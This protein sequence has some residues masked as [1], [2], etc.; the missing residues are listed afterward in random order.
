MAVNTRL[1][2]YA[3]RAVNST[4]KLAKQ[5]SG[6][7]ASATKTIEASFRGLA[8]ASGSLEPPITV[9]RDTYLTQGNGLV[10]TD[11]VDEWQ[12]IRVRPQDTLAAIFERLNLDQY[13]LYQ[14][15]EVD[16]AEQL[17]H[18]KPKQTLKFRIQAGELIDL[19]Y[20]AD[21]VRRF[22]AHR[23]HGK[24]NLKIAYE[25]LGLCVFA[26]SG[27]I[28]NS[29]W[30]A[31]QAADL[32]EQMVMELVK[33]FT[34][35]I[36]FA[37]DIRE[38]DSFTVI[39][40]QYRRDGVRIEDGGILAAEF[41]NQNKRY[42][43]IRFK[44]EAGREEYYTEEGKSPRKAFFRTP[45]NFT[46]ISSYFNLKR[47]HPVLNR[48]RAHR[49]IDYAAPQGTPVKATGDGKVAF[50]GANGGYGKT[51][52][53]QHGEKYSTLYAHLSRFSRGIRRGKAVRQGELIGF[54]GQT[55]LAT[56]PHLHYEFRVNGVHQ[57]PLTVE[58][59][60]AVPLSRNQ[61]IAFKSQTNPVIAK[62]DEIAGE[63][64]Q[65]HPSTTEELTDRRL[66]AMAAERARTPSR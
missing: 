61:L 22:R 34:W 57:N 46:R 9:H 15:L 4:A 11:L 45:V 42:R 28:T 56:G 37:L 16:K 20:E 51:V 32:S 41:V 36:D 58:L 6:A 50:V 35:D 7:S 66:L 21:P 59:P 39:F 29:L 14:L 33:L 54:V 52:V 18:L 47:K 38:G 12:E 55:G 43:A 8:P 49:G 25:E 26:A 17:R 13:Q 27:R 30:Q 5:K 23:Q 64:A 10:D 31:G 2:P 24:F 19:I 65:G 3:D 1:M 63:L 53:L 40:E 48:I 44:D 62:L 60:K